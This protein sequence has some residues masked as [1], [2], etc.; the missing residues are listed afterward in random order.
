MDRH[1]PVLKLIVPNTQQSWWRQLRGRKW[2]CSSAQEPKWEQQARTHRKSKKRE[3]IPASCPSNRCHM[4]VFLLSQINKVFPFE[5]MCTI[6]DSN[7]RFAIEVFKL[8]IYLQLILCTTADAEV[9]VFKSNLHLSV[10]S[11]SHA[12]LFMPTW[13]A[14]VAPSPMD[15]CERDSRN[16]SEG[17][18]LRTVQPV[19][20]WL[21][22]LLC[23][24]GNGLIFWCRI[25]WRVQNAPTL[26]GA[27]LA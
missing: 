25:F 2:Q 7:L 11:G 8:S 22:M 19:G 10:E 18:I 20:L 1:V 16:V 21:L 6:D 4:L 17:A 9:I 14:M 15:W 27:S 12:T 5:F 13:W 23:V 26:R 3:R 24:F